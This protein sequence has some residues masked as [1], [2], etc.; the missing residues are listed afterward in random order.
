MKVGDLVRAKVDG[1]GFISWVSDDPAVVIGIY[2]DDVAIM[3]PNGEE[4]RMF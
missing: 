2:D 4:I 3:F 1:D